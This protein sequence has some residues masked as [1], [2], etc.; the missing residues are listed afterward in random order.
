M[1]I[2]KVGNVMRLF[3]SKR[4]FCSGLWPQEWYSAVCDIAVKSPA[5][6]PNE[7]LRSELI[8]NAAIKNDS[9]NPVRS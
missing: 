2:G 1:G 4:K 8:D 5:L 3:E 6:L 7:N 9:I